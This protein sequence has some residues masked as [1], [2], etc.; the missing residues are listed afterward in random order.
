MAVDHDNVDEGQREIPDFLGCAIEGDSGDVGIVVPAPVLE[1]GLVELGAEQ[2][3][4][5]A[6]FFE[7]LSDSR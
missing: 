6:F 5:D 2:T 4:F 3:L 1:P 7:A